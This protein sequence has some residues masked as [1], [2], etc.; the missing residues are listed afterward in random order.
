MSGTG[1]PPPLRVAL[2]SGGYNCAVD[3]AVKVLNR[4]VAFLESRQVPVVVFSPTVKNPPFKHSGRLVPVPSF[5]LPFRPEYRCALGLTASA[6]R[7]LDAFRPTLLHVTVPDVLGLSALRAAKRLNCPVVGSYH[8]RFDTYCRYYGMD[9][10][11]GTMVNYLRYFYNSCEHVYAPSAA[12][13]DIL[14]GQGI[15][16]DIRL[17]SRGVDRTLFNPAKRDLEWRRSL[18][19]GDDEVVLTFVG[20][21]VLEK[22]LEHF[23]KVHRQLN[24]RGIA[25]RF[26]VVGD[27]PARARLQDWAPDAIFAG[28]QNGDDLARAY[29]SSDIFFNPSIT[30]AFG[31]VTVEAMASGVPS[32]CSRTAGHESMLEEGVTGFLTTPDDVKQAAD[33]IGALALDADLRHGVGAA[34]R[35]ASQRFSWDAVMNAI[36]SYYL[37]ALRTRTAPALPRTADLSAMQD[38]AEAY[39]PGLSKTGT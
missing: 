17:W 3:G 29:A 1:A 23:S 14:Q 6:K 39:S 36:F 4:L 12:M 30:E 20:R 16:R 7:E 8:T 37:D 27:G 35:I 26:L 19:I 13:A 25:H 22:G 2:F 11:E 31:N 15:G 9:W 10:L 38:N 5:P 34:A 18:G 21:L 28:F 24:E 33:L 32:V